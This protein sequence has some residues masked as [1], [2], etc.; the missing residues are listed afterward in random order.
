MNSKKPISRR[1]FLKKSMLAAAGLIASGTL[2]AGYSSFIEPKWVEMKRIR[3]YFERLP[4]SFRG[5]RIVHFS[6][7]HLGHHF[8]LHNL[9]GIAHQIQLEKPDLLCFTGDLFDFA[10][11][12]NLQQTSRILAE[13][14][15]P[16]GKW[17][18]LGNHDY[19][20]RVETT[21]SLLSDGG[22]TVLMNEHKKISLGE[23]SLQIAGVDDMLKG[24]P[25]L[26]HALQHTDP[27]VF[28]LLL[29][30]SANYADIAAA[31]PI[32]LQLSGHSHGGQ[33][34]LPFIG[35][36]VTPPLGDKY[37]MGHYQHERSNLQIYTNRGI[38]TTIHPVRLFCRPEI[39]IITLDENKT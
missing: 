9:K 1:S 15:A 24:R 23:E 29:S 26:V 18:V 13:L 38:G 31:H 2:I 12:E 8:N 14:Q 34:R 39:T 25:D 32:D 7:I 17:A 5:I 11:T 36:L 27:A 16:L 19:Y 20:S 33:V 6:D 3:L 37:I 21:V 28:T 35:A 4:R 22:F 10:F 30:H